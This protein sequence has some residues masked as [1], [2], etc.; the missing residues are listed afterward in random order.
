M[1]SDNAPLDSSRQ[2]LI[3]KRS[4]P[5]E[6]K[7]ASVAIS[8]VFVRYGLK[9]AEGELGLEPGQSRPFDDMEDTLMERWDE[10]QKCN[11]T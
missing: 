1:K 5:A 7:T 2:S 8:Q 6:F 11:Y 10:L 9:L 4:V 3:T